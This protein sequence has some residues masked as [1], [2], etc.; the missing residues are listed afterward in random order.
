MTE[1]LHLWEVD[2]PY[3]ASEGNYYSNDCHAVFESWADFLDEMGDGDL[4][5]N[6]VYRWDWKIADPSDYVDD[7]PEDIPA[8][9]LCI[10]YVGQ[11]KALLRSVEITP[12]SAEDEPAVREWLTIRA[13][14]MRR[15]W[16]PL[17]DAV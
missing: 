16:E 9:A 17:L 10:Y 8:P 4:D 1:V 3:Y 13:E 11:R 12:M 15:V 14:H 2:H 7:D 6:L 5:M